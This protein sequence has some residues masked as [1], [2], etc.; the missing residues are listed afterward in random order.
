MSD[1]SE[2][3]LVG[4]PDPSEYDAYYGRYIDLITEDDI[5]EVLEE[6][7]DEMSN[8]RDFVEDDAIRSQRYA[9]GKWSVG[10]MIGHLADA[11]RVFGFRAFTFAR[12]DAN[13]LPSFDEDAYAVV[14]NES[15][16]DGT[17]CIEDLL[18]ARDANLSLFATFSDAAWQRTGTASG[19]RISVRALAWLMA[20]H[21]RHHQRIL[22]ERYAIAEA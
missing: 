18:S 2:L 22:R 5:L 11:E 21:I 1:E 9:P 12:G 20:G 10:Q 17:S 13:P 3:S 15:E 19:K 16:V 14:A 8:W 7:L 4:R 6:Q